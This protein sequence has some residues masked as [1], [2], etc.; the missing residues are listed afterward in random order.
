V[1]VENCPDSA[2]ERPAQ[3][4]KIASEFSD[5]Y[6]CHMRRRRGLGKD[7]PLK[8]FAE[9]IEQQRQD[10]N[11]PEGH[12]EVRDDKIVEKN[13]KHKAL[14]ILCGQVFEDL[15]IVPVFIDPE[16]FAEQRHIVLEIP[17][18]LK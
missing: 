16:K 9:W 3:D 14:S 5:E 13:E 15:R 6:S 12:T 1:S 10:K 4:Q 11:G 17:V 7:H 2:A 8:K 18:Q